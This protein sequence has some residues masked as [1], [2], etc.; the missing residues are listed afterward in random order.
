MHVALGLLV[1]RKER[2]WQRLQM[3]A[4]QLK[5]SGHLFARGAVDTFVGNARLPPLQM[6]VL[7]SQRLEP[8]PLERVVADI[9]NS[10]LHLPLMLRRPGAAR[11][12]MHPV[13]TA[14]V[15]QLGVD[16]RIKPVRLQDRCLQV[17]EI[18]HQRHTAKRANRIFQNA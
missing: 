15:S 9:A 16:L 4:F 3:R 17:V 1:A 7:L 13:V 11:H 10:S 8:P 14:E 18:E 5:A 12:D 2:R 6:E